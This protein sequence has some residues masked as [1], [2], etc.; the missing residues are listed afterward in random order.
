MCYSKKNGQQEPKA[1]GALIFDEVKVACK[2]M[3]NSRN[4]QLMGLA[5]SSKN[6]ASLNDIYRILQEPEARQTS[7]VFQFLW[8]DLTSSYDIVGPY[9]TSATSVE[10]KFVVA[11]VFETIRLFQHHS[12]ITCAGL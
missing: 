8:R 11:C 7:Y 1:H 10:A 9:Y 5:M 3:W 4:H 2:L 6:M 12:L